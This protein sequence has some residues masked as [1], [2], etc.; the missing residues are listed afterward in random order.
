MRKFVK[1]ALVFGAFAFSSG[2]AAAQVSAEVVTVPGA[3]NKISSE[4]RA[5]FAEKAEL[6]RQIFKAA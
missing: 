3:K 1:S 4:Q 6:I 2:F 5:R